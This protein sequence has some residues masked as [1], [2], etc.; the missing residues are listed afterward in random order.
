MN[1]LKTAFCLSLGL[2]VSPYA[3][4]HDM[5]VP[6]EHGHQIGLF[7]WVPTLVLLALAAGMV[8]RKSRRDE[9]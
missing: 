1:D 6:H 2:L 3:F 9:D 5:P 7:F 4:A 8:W